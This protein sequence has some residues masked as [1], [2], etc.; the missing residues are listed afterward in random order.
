MAIQDAVSLDDQLT[1]DEWNEDYNSPLGYWIE[2]APETSR[3]IS[4]SVFIHEIDDEDFEEY[5]W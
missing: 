1:Y 3:V 4:I 5:K 2:D